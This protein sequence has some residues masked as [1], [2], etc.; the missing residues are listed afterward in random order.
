MK[1]QVIVIRGG[2]TFETYEAYLNYLKSSEIYFSTDKMITWK[3]NL[4]KNLGEEF[5]VFLPQMPNSKNAKY[6]E[7]KIWFERL[8]PFFEEEVIFIGHSLGGLFLAKYLAENVFSKKIKG[9]FLVSVPYEIDENYPKGES[10]ADF[11]IPKDFRNLLNSV[12]NIFLYHSTDDDVVPFSD[13]EKYKKVLIGSK[14]RVF[15]DRGHFR[16]ESFEELE[17]DIRSLF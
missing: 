13:L 4:G 3:E 2:E 10:L 5:Q 8:V 11:I 17:D 6:L 14:F 12:S 7:W 1:K 16:L 15:N 9:L